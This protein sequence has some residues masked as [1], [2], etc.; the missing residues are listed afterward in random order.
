MADGIR[1]LSDLKNKFA[2]YEEY[3]RC[4]TDLNRYIVEINR[5]NKQ[6]AGQDEIGKTYHQTVDKATEGLTEQIASIRKRLGSIA[7][8]GDRTVK[9]MN[10]ADDEATQTIG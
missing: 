9:N 1:V 10:N 5:I 2:N 8:A 4:L 7:D 3:E 6:S